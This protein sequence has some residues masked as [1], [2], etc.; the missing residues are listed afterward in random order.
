M[1]RREKSRRRFFRRIINPFQFRYRQCYIHDRR[2]TF[3][4]AVSA[5]QKINESL[6]SVQEILIERM[7]ASQESIVQR[8]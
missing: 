4:D 5:R 6:L 2:P 8:T 7:N 1:D 3:V